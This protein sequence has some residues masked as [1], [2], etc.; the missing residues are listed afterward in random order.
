MPVASHMKVGIEPY[1]WM[2]GRTIPKYDPGLEPEEFPSTVVWSPEATHD[3][4]WAPYDVNAEALADIVTV[5]MYS[6]PEVNPEG[7]VWWN[8]TLWD[9][10]SLVEVPWQRATLLDGDYLPTPDGA[11]TNLSANALPHQATIEWDTATDASTQVLYQVSEPSAPISPTIPFSHTLY[12]PRV[13]SIIDPNTL[14]YSPVDT[15]PVLHH[16]VVLTNLPENYT[17][18]YVALS[19]SFQGAACITSASA[20]THAKSDS[21]VSTQLGGD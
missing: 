17:I 14:Q 7:G 20:F 13:F 18:E 3:F 1:G 8:D 19:R 16:Q 4:D 11:I 10:A 15:T 12:M 5:I 21:G 2:S 6:N 9:T